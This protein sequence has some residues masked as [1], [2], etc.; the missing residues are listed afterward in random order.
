MKGLLGFY[1]VSFHQV[2]IQLFK[3]AMMQM[4]SNTWISALQNPVY[5]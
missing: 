1:N 2:A 4:S 5:D 3:R